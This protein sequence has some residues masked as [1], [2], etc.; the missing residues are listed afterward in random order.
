MKISLTLDDSL[1]K[2]II[3]NQEKIMASV[4]DVKNDLAQIQSGINT[5]KQ[6][7][8]DLKA[9][10]GGASQAQIDEL[11]A[12]AQSVLATESDSA[13]A[14]GGTTDPNA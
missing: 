14:T 7:I 8:A 4:D 5:L 11:H 2:T 3:S 1:L 12:L 9:A 10:G 13:P 6:A